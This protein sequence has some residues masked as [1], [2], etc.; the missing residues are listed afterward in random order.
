MEDLRESQ[1]NSPPLPAISCVSRN[2]CLGLPQEGFYGMWTMNG[3]AQ[4]MN[5]WEGRLNLNMTYFMAYFFGVA[6]VETM[7]RA[8][9][10][11]GSQGK[12]STPTSMMR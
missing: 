6:L 1:N 10:G 2:T 11:A 12:A 7:G 9:W 8:R 5:M 3:S 4:Y